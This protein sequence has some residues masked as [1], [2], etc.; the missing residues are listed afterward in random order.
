MKCFLIHN[1]SKWETKKIN[2]VRFSYNNSHDPYYFIR[3]IQ[4]RECIKCGKL[5]RKKINEDIIIEE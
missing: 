2:M 4:E 5:V 3:T 1:W